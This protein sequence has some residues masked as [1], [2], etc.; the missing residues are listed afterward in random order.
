MTETGEKRWLWKESGLHA[1]ALLL[2]AAVLWVYLGLGG[3]NYRDPLALYIGGDGVYYAAQVKV[4]L[5]TG[6]VFHHPDLGAPFGLYL[7][8]FAHFDALHLLIM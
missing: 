1:L 3:V 4:M 2:T 5:E 8:D 7:Y 6:W